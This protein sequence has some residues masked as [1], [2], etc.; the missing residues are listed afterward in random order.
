MHPNQETTCVF[1]FARAAALRG[2]V[3]GSAASH[4]VY[5]FHGIAIVHERLREGVASDD[6]QVVLDRDA[7]RINVQLGEEVGNRNGLIELETFAV[8][9]DNHWQ[10]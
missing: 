8:Q 2:F 10:S 9:R 5:D 4:E 3:C 1:V 7:S 6:R